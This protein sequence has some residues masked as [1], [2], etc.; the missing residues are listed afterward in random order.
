MKEIRGSDG[1]RVEAGLLPQEA[2]F[3][4][5]RGSRSL[6]SWPDHR[7]LPQFPTVISSGDTISLS[8]DIFIFPPIFALCFRSYST[9]TRSHSDTTH[10]PLPVPGNKGLGRQLPHSYGWDFG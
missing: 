3:V 4:D 8:S 7:R 5:V 6:S 10:S 2:S 9:K 1:A